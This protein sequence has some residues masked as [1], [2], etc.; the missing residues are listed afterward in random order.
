MREIDKKDLRALLSEA[1]KFCGAIH[2]YVG[3]LNLNSDEVTT[4]SSDVKL[5]RFIMEQD[6]SFTESFISYNTI[7]IQWHLTD[8]IVACTNSENYNDKIGE[9]L[10]IEIP[11]NNTIGLKTDMKLKW[12][13]E[14][15]TTGNLH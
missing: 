4:F 5:L 14:L 10:G 12:S 3:L 8:L 15:T 1:I 9:E 7:S 13:P 11:L 2:K 6:K